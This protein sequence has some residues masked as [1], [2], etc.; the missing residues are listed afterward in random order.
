MKDSRLTF[1]KEAEGALVPVLL[2]RYG[3]SSGNTMSARASR[4]ASKGRD[5]GGTASTE[6]K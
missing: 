2:E 5:L 6:H 3:D 4:G 1:T